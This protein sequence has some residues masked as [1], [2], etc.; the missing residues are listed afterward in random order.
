V[1]A[2]EWWKELHGKMTLTVAKVTLSSTTSN[3]KY[4]NALHSNS[5]T[6]KYKA[7]LIPILRCLDRIN[8]FQDNKAQ[9][10]QD[11][12]PSI[13]DLYKD[14]SHAIGFVSCRLIC[15]IWREVKSNESTP[16]HQSFGMLLINM[17]LQHTSV[18]S[19]HAFHPHVLVRSNVTR[20]FQKPVASWKCT[21]CN[22]MTPS[23]QNNVRICMYRCAPCGFHLCKECFTRIP[24]HM[25][26][27]TRT[28][29]SSSCIGGISRMKT[30]SPTSS[31]SS[32]PH[33]MEER[34]LY[35][36]DN[37]FQLALNQMAGLSGPAT[38]IVPADILHLDLAN[39]IR[40]RLMEMP[41]SNGFEMLPLMEM[42]LD[43]AHVKSFMQHLTTSICWMAPFLSGVK[44]QTLSFLGPF[45]WFST[46]T[47]ANLPTNSSNTRGNKFEAMRLK[48]ERQFEAKKVQEML[49]QFLKVL[50]D[51]EKH[52]KK[53][54]EAVLCW[55]ASC[56]EAN[57]LRGR[58]DDAV[59]E[60]TDGFLINLSAAIV[61]NALVLTRQLSQYCFEPSQPLYLTPRIYNQ[62][63]ET[64]VKKIDDC[65]VE[66]CKKEHKMSTS[67][68]FYPKY[69]RHMGVV[70]DVCH[71]SDL[72]GV[73]YKCANCQDYDL[74]SGCYQTFRQ[75]AIE[76]IT[77]L[78]FIPLIT[79]S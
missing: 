40:W 20:V 5:T 74:C 23:K 25:E 49:A 19:L 9:G 11:Q 61:R 55:L 69:T 54:R 42:F 77:N 68:C 4:T 30:D 73:R 35:R 53:T 26:D 64:P 38:Q 70:C 78:I 7:I 57:C 76:R 56:I 6:T 17:L 21:V 65:R 79:F 59:E 2:E 14:L 10:I 67:E 32:S 66:V 52:S 45:F 12:Q 24:N 51:P 58:L 1:N 28:S 31:S 62:E 39:A 33:R 60:S 13:D 22:R 50:L 15:E 18:G 41:V 63:N 46:I 3:D 47:E 8:Q 29:T 16:P 72:E 75:K 37:F 71:T 44:V 43:M 34:V 36:M 48:R 27:G